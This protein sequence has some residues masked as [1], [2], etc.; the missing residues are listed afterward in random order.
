MQLIISM[1]SVLYKLTPIEALNAVT[2]NSAYAMGVEDIL[3]TIT[4][5]K[6]ANILI[7]NN[8]PSVEYIPY[9]YGENKIEKVIIGG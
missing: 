9:A 7:T 8:I 5:G 3:G 6:K 2:I 4:V 1:A